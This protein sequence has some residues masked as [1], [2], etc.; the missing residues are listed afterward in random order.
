[1]IGFKVRVH[2]RFVNRPSSFDFPGKIFYFI[3]WITGKSLGLLRSVVRE[4][5][6]FLCASM[7]DPLSKSGR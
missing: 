4:R 3:F 7:E 6:D 1:M 5:K 2:G